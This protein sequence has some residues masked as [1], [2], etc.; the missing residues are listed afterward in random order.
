MRAGPPINGDMCLATELQS[1]CA[2]VHGNESSIDGYMCHKDVF[3]AYKIDATPVS[4]S[5]NL[6]Q[7]VSKCC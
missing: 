7:L 2:C 6:R 3:N 1:I 5:Y 4:E